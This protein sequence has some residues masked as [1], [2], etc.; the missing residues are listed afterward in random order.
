MGRVRTITLSA[1][2]RSWLYVYDRKLWR[3]MLAIMPRSSRLEHPRDSVT[4]R[5]P[6]DVIERIERMLGCQVAG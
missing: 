5:G 2:Q 4:L 1:D 3:L 6:S